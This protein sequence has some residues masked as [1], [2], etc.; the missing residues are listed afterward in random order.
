MDP[1]EL[2]EAEEDSA[3]PLIGAGARRT[4]AVIVGMCEFLPIEF[5]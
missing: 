2:N 3:P 5:Y 1:S 4:S